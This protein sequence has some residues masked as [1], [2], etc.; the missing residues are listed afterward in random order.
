MAA[1]SAVPILIP[2]EPDEFWSQIRLIIREEVERNKAT[3]VTTE[4]INIMEISGLTEKPLFKIEEVC[5]L[6]KV[7]KPTIYDW[8][9][10]G[11]LK[12]VKIRSRVYFLGSDIR[13]LMQA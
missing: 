11:K 12:R 9:K 5:S 1:N 2:F 13:Q 8:I 3:H 4:N 7:T 10:H 6:F